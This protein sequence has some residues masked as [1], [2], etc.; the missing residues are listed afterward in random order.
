MATPK[1]DGR[2]LP[3]R[4]FN[5]AVKPYAF[6]VSFA[7]FIVSWAILAGV[8]VGQLLDTFPGQLVGVTALAAVILLWA[9]WWGQRSTWMT[10]GLLVTVGVW[11]SVWAIVM[12]DTGWSN[13]SGWLGSAWALASA[14]AWLLEV[15]DKGAR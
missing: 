4:V 9:G 8:A 3:W 5:R 6:A 7:T 14:G 10:H 2:T 12:L 11:S 1:T 13:V 15:S